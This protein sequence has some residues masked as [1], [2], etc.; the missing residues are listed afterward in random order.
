[1]KWVMHSILREDG[2]EF[3]ICP[4]ITARGTKL[5]AANA[6]KD[7]GAKPCEVCMPMDYTPQDV[8]MVKDDG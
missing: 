1:M 8:M 2:G 5:S 6:S 7:F 4:D 3:T